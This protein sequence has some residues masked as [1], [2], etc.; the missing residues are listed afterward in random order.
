MPKLSLFR[1]P[2]VVQPT[3]E[4]LQRLVYDLVRERVLST[5]GPDGSF[6]VTIRSGNDADAFFSETFAE[7]IA[8]DVAR[9]I[10]TNSVASARLIA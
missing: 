1:R 4:D 9:R 8:W 6:A 7:S 10:E 3:D 5:L 2:A